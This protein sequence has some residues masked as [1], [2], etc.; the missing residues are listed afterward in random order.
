VRN[1]YFQSDTTSLSDVEE[2]EE[3]QSIDAAEVKIIDI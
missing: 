2:N 1:A 3:S